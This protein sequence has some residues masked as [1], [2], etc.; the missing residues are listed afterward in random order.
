MEIDLFV[1]K[2]QATEQYV[3]FFFFFFLVP[4]VLLIVFSNLFQVHD[5]L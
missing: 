1:L 5:K 4:F 3:F 2:D